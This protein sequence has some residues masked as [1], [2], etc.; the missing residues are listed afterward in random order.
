MNLILQLTDQS[1]WQSFYNNKLQ[2]GHMTQTDLENL[3]SFIQREGY[4]ESVQKIMDGVPFSPPRQAAISKHA[5]DKK[6]I[7]F[8]YPYPELT[9]LKYL[10]WLLQ[11]HYDHL[12]PRNLYSFRPCTGVRQA[13]ND[14]QRIPELSRM[15]SYKVD[16]SNYFNSIPVDRL[17]DV[18]RKNLPEEQVLVRFFSAILSDPWVIENGVRICNPDKGIMAGT[19]TST[20]LANLY[21]KELD[22]QFQNSGR[23]YARYSDDIITFAPTL[24]E[25]EENIRWIHQALSVAGLS[26]NA[27]KEC[28]TAPDDPWVFL[29]F[30]FH[31]GKIDVAPASVEKIKA[32]MRRKTRALLRWKSRKN[33]T[34]EQ[35]A[36]AF[37]RVFN[38][39]M[40]ENPIEHDLTWARWYFPMIN[41]TDS[42]QTIDHYMQQC[43]RTLVTGKHTKSAYNCRYEDMK[44]LGYIT[45][46]NRFYSHNPDI[47]EETVDNS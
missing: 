34:G 45:L 30:Q 16:I 1:C 31:D 43:I 46:V 5:S 47:S 18:L 22:L 33:A 21:L 24:T 38:R 13:V 26:I 8:I 15:W 6:R 37:I 32:K 25:L 28:R 10:T 29:G 23:Y 2:G 41:T 14:L 12:F 42:L 4:R 11:R 35:A 20:F 7:V 40:F 9:V 27:R 36:T 3:A 44:R 17:M 39:K 19:P